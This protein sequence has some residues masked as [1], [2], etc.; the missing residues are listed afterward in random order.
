M[1]GSLSGRKKEGLVNPFRWGVGVLLLCILSNSVCLGLY[2][3]SDRDANKP[4]NSALNLISDIFSVV[5]M[6]EALLKIIA[7][8]FI[9]HKYSYLRE[10]WNFIDFV[11]V[12]FGY[13]PSL[14]LI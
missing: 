9:F 12:C 5:F 10:G 6:I 4:F 3:Y 1:F 7:M 8:G 2:D 13:F 14:I 11:I